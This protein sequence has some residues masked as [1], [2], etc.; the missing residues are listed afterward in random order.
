MG[1][2]SVK[3]HGH[4]RSGHKHQR[5]RHQRSRHQRSRHQRRTRRH[6]GGVGSSLNPANKSR[7]SSTRTRKLAVS[8]GISRKIILEQAHKAEAAERARK[9]VAKANRERIPAVASKRPSRKT[10]ALASFSEEEE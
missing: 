2:T 9:L 4:K 3:A 6:Y 1:N 10:P 8:P 7:E 5:S